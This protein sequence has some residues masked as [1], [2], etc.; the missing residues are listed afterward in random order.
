MESKIKKVIIENFG[1]IDNLNL[2][3]KIH[4]CSLLEEAFDIN[5][6]DQLYNEWESFKD[7]VVSIKKLI[8]EQRGC[9]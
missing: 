7:I 5:I 1:K 6:D 4:L 9:L 3:E 8:K 2:A